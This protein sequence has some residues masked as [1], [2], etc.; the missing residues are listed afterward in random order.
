MN[1]DRMPDGALILARAMTQRGIV[2]TIGIGVTAVLLVFEHFG[3]CDFR[4]LPCPKIG[5]TM[6][7]CFLGLCRAFPR[8]SLVV[9][10]AFEAFVTGFTTGPFLIFIEKAL[11]GPTT[12]TLTERVIFKR[13]ESGHL[14]CP[15]LV[16]LLALPSLACLQGMQSKFATKLGCFNMALFLALSCAMYFCRLPRLPD[17]EEGKFEAE[18]SLINLFHNIIT[19]SSIFYIGRVACGQGVEARDH[20]L[21]LMRAGRLADSVLNHVLKNSIANIATLIELDEAS[22]IGEPLTRRDILERLTQ[23]MRW[24]STRQVLV[25][26]AD[27]RYESVKTPIDVRNW[28]RNVSATRKAECQVWIR[29]ENLVC[30][31]EKMAFLVLEN[32]LS[33]AAAYGDG[34]IGVSAD[35][36][37]GQVLLAVSNGLPPDSTLTNALLKQKLEGHSDRGLGTNNHHDGA[38]ASK[39]P[40]AKFS[41]GVGLRHIQLA[42]K[43]G[44]GT[45]DLRIIVGEDSRRTV[46]L[47]LRLPAT[48]CFGG[49]TATDP[50][51]CCTN[52][53]K[54]EDFLRP[55]FELSPNQSTNR[56]VAVTE[57]LL[58]PFPLAVD[59]PDPLESLS[60]RKVC[61]LDDAKIICK[62]YEKL[63]LR[64]LG[65]N[66]ASSVVCCPTNH[67]EVRQFMDTASGDFISG[68][69]MQQTVP[70]AVTILDQNLDFESEHTLLGTDLAFELRHK[71]NYE[72]LIV[73]RSGNSTSSDVESYMQGGCVDLCLGKDQ[74]NRDVANAIEAAYRKKSRT[75][76]C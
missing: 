42:C 70:A 20:C 60:G 31:D 10:R 50:V 76:A 61:A 5:I 24:C 73:L 29:P 15:L 63:V 35:Y 22:A 55:L 59:A 54:E 16:L 7:L 49:S 32:A 53:E 44:R 72:G 48:I 47:E 33:N 18:M 25:D 68:G 1:R 74:R 71:R 27:G 37:D 64:Q 41:T 3:G 19:G 67:Q 65:A 17:S 14:P 30:F 43:G 9:N 8:D 26:L 34:T 56:P 11:T 75:G 23:A 38:P 57:P 21:D 13:M 12:G 39:L 4:S 69:G 2:Q 6:T 36:A 40:L 46:V 51:R 52:G 58:H 28:L 45:L 62:G 66:V